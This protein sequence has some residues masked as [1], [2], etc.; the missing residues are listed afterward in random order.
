MHTTPVSL[1]E[2]LRQPAEEAAWNRFV[3][4][5][6]PLL[7]HWAKRLGL[8]GP[9]AADLVQDVFTILVQ[10]LPRFTYQPSKRFRGWLWTVFLNKW[11]ERQRRRTLP[12]VGERALS[13]LASP[14]G[15]LAVC[16]ADYRQYLVRRAAKLIQDEFRPNTWK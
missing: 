11:R 5:Y 3:A 9:D 13:G 4:L 15:A 10:E 7:C 6:A 8:Q 14:D 2:R 16:E 12:V 1:L